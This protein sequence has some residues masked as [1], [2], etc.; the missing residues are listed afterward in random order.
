MRYRYS[1]P[2]VRLALTNP[3]FEVLTDE[4]EVQTKVPIDRLPDNRVVSYLEGLSISEVKTNYESSK[5]QELKALVESDGSIM[6][7]LE[8]A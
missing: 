4:F 5:L 2:K 3:T 1:S 8:D 6:E 7:L